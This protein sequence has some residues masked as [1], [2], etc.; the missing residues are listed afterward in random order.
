[1]NYLRCLLTVLSTL[2]I[3]VHVSGSS[4]KD[5]AKAELNR[6]TLKL[7]NNEISED[8]YLKETYAQIS[9]FLAKRIF[10]SNA[11]MLE[12][13]SVFREIAQKSNKTNP[14]LSYYALLLN[15]AQMAG[16]SGEM[17]YYT[18]K[19]SSLNTEEEEPS[20]SS[21]TSEL[22]YYLARNA[23]DEI[24]NL[25]LKKKEIIFSLPVK[26]QDKVISRAE[27][28][29]ASIVLE[30]FA[31]AFSELKDT[32]TVNEIYHL[33]KQVADANRKEFKGN[34][35]GT[36]YT[37]YCFARVI[38]HKG[39][40]ENAPQYIQEAFNI[41]ERLFISPEADNNFKP[42]IDESLTEWKIDFYLE[43]Y[44]ADSVDFYIS[45][46]EKNGFPE[47][48]YSFRQFIQVSKA[49]AF[50][51]KGM[52]KEANNALFEAIDIL[53]ASLTAKAKE[54]DDFFYAHAEAEE[55]RF[56]I[57]AVN[58]S[59]QEKNKTILFISVF[60]VLILLTA[61]FFYYRERIK[62]KKQIDSLNDA[63]NMQI[64]SLEEMKSLIA[65]DE[66]ERLGKDLHD[67]F[68]PG[69]VSM[70]HQISLMLHNTSDEKQKAALQSLKIQAEESYNVLRNKSHRMA[71]MIDK[72]D[73]RQFEER[74]KNL[75]ARAL[76]D[77]LYN[78][79]VHIAEGIMQHISLNVR[80]EFLRIIQE[81]V[82][83][84]IKY[85]SAKNI[86]VLL[87]EDDNCAILQ[88][89]D[90]GKGFNVNN[91]KKGIGLTSIKER[92]AS[93]GSSIQITSGKKGTSIEVSL[94]IL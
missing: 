63:A 71:L 36:T 35:I 55:K 13:L 88:I 8:Q 30:K 47:E 14:Y 41:L 44:N 23:F 49:K 75:M 4:P 15:Q 48:S 7:K 51:R 29:Q 26:V 17:F 54:T 90:D 81:A 82:T 16:R 19:I 56:E 89:T 77:D 37:E 2:F 52:Y 79:D 84:I 31:Q 61:S 67:N 10:F 74:I 9:S 45:K 39:S 12:N 18:K 58:Q 28:L 87:Y 6:T 27:M 76:P 33:A 69:L 43:N 57:A 62:T 70:M 22:E 92:A 50:I 40:V 24:Q 60:S 86:A 32:H 20:I 5:S 53:E 42:I 94:K 11:E 93:I 73:D 65:I 3:S 59:I 91:S 21:I 66:Q 78:K 1:M 46:L 85:A 83:N 25:Y 64:A 34:P 80:I 38:H 72:L 68:S